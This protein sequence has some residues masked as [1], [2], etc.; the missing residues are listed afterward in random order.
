MEYTLQISV[1]HRVGTLQLN[2]DVDMRAPIISIEGP[3]GSGK[4]TLLKILAGLVR[5]KYARIRCRDK[6]WQDASTFVPPWLRDVGYVPQEAHLF[7]HLNVHE[8]I[9][10]GLKAGNVANT[11]V[12]RVLEEFELGHL[13]QRF[14]RHLSGGE[15]QRVALARAVANKP[16]LM[17]LDEP[18]SAMDKR[19]RTDIRKNLKAWAADN[20]TVLLLVSHDTEDTADFVVA[21][22]GI[23]DSDLTMI[24][25]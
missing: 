23:I 17:L 18:F 16:K 24:R 6:V 2:F 19:L 4:S 11:D 14:P 21:R 9:C 13:R 12:G 3:S 25:T 8:N 1:K 10:F 20:N 5:P 7:P 22:Y 15:K